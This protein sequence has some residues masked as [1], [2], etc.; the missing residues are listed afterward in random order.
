[1]AQNMRKYHVSI[2]AKEKLFSN[3]NTENTAEK[4]K[5]RPLLVIFFWKIH[6][7]VIVEEAQSFNFDSK[8]DSFL[9]TNTVC[10]LVRQ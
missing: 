9:T 4:Q 1:M 10:D 6:L 7:R 2:C 3:F 8:S 5:L